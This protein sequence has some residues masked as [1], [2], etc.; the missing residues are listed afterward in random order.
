MK[1]LPEYQFSSDLR[2]SLGGAKPKSRLSMFKHSTAPNI[3]VC[4]CIQKEDVSVR[5]YSA[6]NAMVVRHMWRSLKRRISSCS[7][8]KNLASLLYESDN[9]LETKL[10]TTADIRAMSHAWFFST[11]DDSN[12]ISDSLRVCNCGQLDEAFQ[13]LPLPCERPTNHFTSRGSGSISLAVMTAGQVIFEKIRNNRLQKLVS[14]PNSPFAAYPRARKAV[15]MKLTIDSS[16]SLSH[17][18]AK[19]LSERLRTLLSKPPPG[20][21]GIVQFAAHSVDSLQ[22]WF[23]HP[24]LSHLMTLPIFQEMIARSAK[25]VLIPTV[26]T[27]TPSLVGLI[28]T[29]LRFDAIACEN[30][31]EAFDFAHLVGGD[32]SFVLAPKKKSA[33]RKTKAKGKYFPA[34]KADKIK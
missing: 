22:D 29:Q 16:I 33:S 2:A 19:Q 23:P 18:K 24:S 20:N 21:C 30:F 25:P 10:Y 17:Q 32:R 26:A 12:N 4:P 6:H 27:A 7:L 34:S 15:L 9:P 1:G 31:L 14:F 5:G 11:A 13:T 28:W 8:F 3:L